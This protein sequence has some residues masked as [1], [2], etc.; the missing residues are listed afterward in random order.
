MEVG[1]EDCV[2]S[3]R[4][5]GHHW[6]KHSPHTDAH[7]RDSHVKQGPKGTGTATDRQSVLKPKNTS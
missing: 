6:G 4:D 1:E 5:G 3:R 2:L 7:T